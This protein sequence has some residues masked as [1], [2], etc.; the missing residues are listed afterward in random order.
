MTTKEFNMAWSL[1]QTIVHQ[2]ASHQHLL[3]QCLAPMQHLYTLTQTTSPEGIGLHQLVNTVLGLG[4]HNSQATLWHMPWLLAQ[5][6]RH[7]NL[8]LVS[9]HPVNMGLQM[10][11][12]QC[13][14]TGSVGEDNGKQQG[15][16]SLIQTL[17]I[18]PVLN[19]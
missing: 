2:A 8:H 18:H 11:G 17:G 19:A 15:Q 4:L 16:F 1:S 14:L 12:T 7:P 3:R 9:S 13:T 6:T 5:T 10:G